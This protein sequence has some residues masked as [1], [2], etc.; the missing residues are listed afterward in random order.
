M[1]SPRSVGARVTGAVA[2]VRRRSALVDHVVRTLEHYS[3]VR[4][5]ILAG[6]VTY[7]GFLSFFPLLALS[8]FV[9]G[10]VARVFPQADDAL[11]AAI[12]QLF[13]SVFGSASTQLS[14]SDLEDLAAKLGILAVLGGLY[15][16]LGW[17][18]AMRTALLTVF[19]LPAEE[20]PNFLLGKARDLATLAAVGTMLL[21]SVTVSSVVSRFTEELL[22]WAGGTADLASTL[23]ALSLLLGL[24]SA[25]LL[26]WMLFRL[27]ARPH[28]PSRSL[29]LGA[30]LG[31]VAFEAL[32]WLA[33][34]LLA[35][36]VSMPAF[37]LFG[38]ALILI[39]WINYFSQ[40]TL[41]AAAWAHTRRTSGQ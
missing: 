15:T 23:T 10:Y 13:P 9:V 40:V 33:S 22:D 37:Q 24:L 41:Y 14:L 8:F 32:K 17:L 28:T 11:T 18:S 35:H 4:G 21:V 5:N 1:T 2:D 36:T 16:G 19:E 34:Y 12:E 27:L 38:I 26:F 31:A 29:W 20:Q 39:L 3:S 6:A 25:I 30:L 7:F